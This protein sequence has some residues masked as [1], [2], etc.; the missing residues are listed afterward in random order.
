VE[1]TVTWEGKPEI[2]PTPH[3]LV[4]RRFVMKDAR[5]YSLRFR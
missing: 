3:R 2:N 5:L 4:R 1:H